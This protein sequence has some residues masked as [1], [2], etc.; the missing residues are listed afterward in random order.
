[1]ISSDAYADKREHILTSLHEI[2]A[3]HFVHLV[4]RDRLIR[5]RAHPRLNRGAETF[6]LELIHDALHAA[7]AAYDVGD[8][9]ADD[10]AQHAIQ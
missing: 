5:A 4:R 2:G 10:S 9:G 6:R 1:M 8:H 7:V 3:E